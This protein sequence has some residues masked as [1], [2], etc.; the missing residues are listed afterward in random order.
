MAVLPAPIGF[1][2]SRKREKQRV[3]AHR[4]HELDRQWQAIGIGAEGQRNGRKAGD[5]GKRRKRRESRHPLEMQVRIGMIRWKGSYRW[6]CLS[7]H[8]HDDDIDLLEEVPQCAAC[9]YR[10]I[11]G[12]PKC[13][14]RHGAS[15]HDE[16]LRHCL[17]RQNIQFDRNTDW[18]RTHLIDRVEPIA[19]GDGWRE[20]RT[21]LHAAEFIETRRHWFTGTVSHDTRGTVNVL[22]LVEGREAIV[23]SP[24]GAFPP[25]LV[26]YA[27]TFI[28]PAAVGPYTI[29]PH[30]ES[31]GTECATM[32]AY[33]RVF[34]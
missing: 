4:R 16:G 28:L 15:A 7:Q 24:T 32:K 9:S 31:V 14:R 12:A 25:F 20:E 11:E 34:A 17:C 29:R 23:E 19:Q 2:P 18:V 3:F 22:N 8:R 10:A 6:S 33:V 1:K 26:H 30:G 21:G 5:V 13:R 27:E